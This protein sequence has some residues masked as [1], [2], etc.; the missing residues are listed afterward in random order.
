MKKMILSTTLICI[1]SCS[2]VFGAET[3]K[4]R[5]YYEH[6]PKVTEARVKE[7]KTLN[8]MTFGIEKD[9]QNAFKAYRHNRMSGKSA[10]NK[11][12]IDD[13]KNAPRPN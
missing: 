11:N 5:Y 1:S 9:C 8:E 7:C 6:N 12:V 3:F 13:F 4:T 10:I 2:Q